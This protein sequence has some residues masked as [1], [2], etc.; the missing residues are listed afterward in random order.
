MIPKY[1]FHIGE[2]AESALKLTNRKGMYE[3][4]LAGCNVAAVVKEGRT[5]GE[6]IFRIRD[7]HIR[8]E[9]AE[10]DKMESKE[11]FQRYERT[12]A[13]EIVAQCVQKYGVKKI[14]WYDLQHDGK[15]ILE[16]AEKKGYVRRLTDNE[17]EIANFPKPALDTGRQ[18]LGHSARRSAQRSFVRRLSPK[19]MRNPRRI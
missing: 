9:W 14:R 19:R 8:I 12:L 4:N 16:R 7:D 17:A 5:I 6:L 10:S 1:S 18:R 11:F 15:K 2:D 3:A 13:E